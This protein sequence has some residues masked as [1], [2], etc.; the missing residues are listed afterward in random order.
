VDVMT[1]MDLGRDAML[2][3]LLLSAPVLGISLIAGLLVSIFQAATQIQEMTL[4]FVPK[5]IACAIALAVFGP[6]MVNVMIRF[7]DQTWDLMRVVGR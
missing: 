3:A 1:V 2:T 7:T 6:W 5:M 4:T